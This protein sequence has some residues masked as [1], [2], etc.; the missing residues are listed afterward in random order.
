[1]QCSHLAFPGTRYHFSR[2]PV[3]DNHRRSPNPD[4]PTVK[5]WQ[6]LVRQR[7]FS[8]TELTWMTSFSTTFL[9]LNLFSSVKLVTIKISRSEISY[10]ILWILHK[11]GQV[12]YPKHRVSLPFCTP[13]VVSVPEPNLKSTA[14]VTSQSPG[15]RDNIQKQWPPPSF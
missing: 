5:V 8:P 9:P 6:E 15:Y 7:E 11:V 1:M 2:V 12:F 4:I 13:P 3:T 14:Q 10:L